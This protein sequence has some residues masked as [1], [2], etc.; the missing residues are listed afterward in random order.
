MKVTPKALFATQ[1]VCFYRSER[2]F[3]NHRG[4]FVGQSL[5]KTERDCGAL[6]NR[7]GLH[8]GV[9][10]SGGILTPVSVLIGNDVVGHLRFEFNEAA[11]PAQVVPE[12]IVRDAKQPRLE[13]AG[14]AK[15]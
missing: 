4:F 3:E 2:A 1:N 7:E 11:P 13:L 5:L 6:L 8:R 10:I 12:F 15:C 14:G 9:Q